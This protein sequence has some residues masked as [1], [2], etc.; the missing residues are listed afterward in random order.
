MISPPKAMLIDLDDTILALS[1]SADK[2]WHQVC[3]QFAG[4]AE[5][6]TPQALFNAIRKGRTWFWSDPQRHHR[7]RMDLEGARREIVDQAFDWLGIDAPELANEI[8]DTYS[9]EREGG[10]CLFPGAV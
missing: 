10:I 5:G 2:Y 9:R 6:L 1:D 4:Q 7:G 3:E 8:A